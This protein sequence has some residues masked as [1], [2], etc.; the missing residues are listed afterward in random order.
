MANPITFEFNGTQYTLEYSR[1]TVL[2]MERNGTSVNMKE[3]DTIPLSIMDNLFKGSFLMH[4]RN[5]KEDTM[6]AIWKEIP[7]KEDFIK[8]LYE[9]YVS[10]MSS[11]MDEPDEEDEKKVVWTQGK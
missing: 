1:R 10:P 7:N 11:L 3:Y 8:A 9:L 4:H 5:V 2:R 6:N